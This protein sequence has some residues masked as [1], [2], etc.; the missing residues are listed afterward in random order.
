MSDQTNSSEGEI[1]IY[2]S[3]A[4]L[5]IFLCLTG[6]ATLDKSYVQADRATFEAIAPYY[7]SKVT[8][9]SELRDW[10]KDL[11]LEVTKSWEERLIEAEK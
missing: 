8:S 2:K 4:L 5:A 7:E 9:D 6:C 1:M 3:L 11:R 10:E